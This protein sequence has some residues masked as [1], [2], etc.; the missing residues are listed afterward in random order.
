[1]ST[2]LINTLIDPD[3]IENN[4]LYTLYSDIYFP[5]KFTTTKIN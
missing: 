5:V 3:V 2:L 4:I 1:V